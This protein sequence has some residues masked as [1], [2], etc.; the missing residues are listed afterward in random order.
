MKKLL[1]LCFL[2]L[3]GAAF[4]QSPF[5]PEYVQGEVLVKFKSNM[6]GKMTPIHSQISA[7]EVE[8]L[9]V[10]DI[11]RVRIPSNMSVTR[12]LQHY[13]SQPGVEF[14]EPNYIAHTFVVPNDPSWGSQYGPAKIQCPTGWDVN[15]GSSS[16]VIAIIDTGVLTSHPDLSGKLV[17]GYD[18]VNGDADANDDNGHGTHCAGI[19]SAATS[20]GIG[21][22]GV[23]WNCRI[24][25][26]KVLNASGSGTFANIA[27]GINF[28]TT[29]GAKVISLSL[30]GS[31]GSSTLQA[32][33]DNAVANGV[34]V[35]AAAGNSNT[36]AA[37]YPAFYTNAIAV[38]ST[39][40]ND[41]RSS[42]SNYGTWVD[43]A[44]PGSSIYSTYLNNGYA[45][46]SGTSM[47]TPHVA[48]MAG[49]LYS[50]LGSSTSAATIR[51]R[52]EN[53]CD[54]VGSFVV[55]GRVNVYRALTNGSG[56]TAPG[57]PTLAGTAGNA[58]ATLSWNAVSGA[59][60]YTLKRSNTS[61]GPYTNIASGL[62]TTNYVN[63]GLTNGTTYYYVVSAANSVGSSPNSNQVTIVPTAPPT[64]GQI[65]VNPSFENGDAPWMQTAGVIGSFTQH[66]ARTGSRN[67]WMCGYG[68]TS[69]DTLYQQVTIPANATTA[70]LNLYMK[71]TTAE[72]TTRT[73]YDRCQVQIRNSSNSVLQTLATYSNL[74]KSTGYVLRSFN[75]AA[76]R[77][78]TIRVYFNATEDSTLQTSFVVDDVTLN[79][80]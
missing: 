18:F 6:A 79:V 68:A 74:N 23:G 63:T 27:S 19:A 61:G 38:A 24:M 50:H 75:V 71:I 45:T 25:P 41:A 2:G 5:G 36:T 3:A 10:A 47:A 55:K 33:V 54:P 69:T 56:G 16:V 17:A 32:A 35:V 46:L 15:Q 9:P 62:T 44:A 51:A 78:Q 72:T 67:A 42:F 1:N 49:L 22:A 34:T 64:G 60:S 28:A 65:I 80:N 12:A 7:M 70:T 26:V 30:G 37:S 58:Q 66:P 43:V 11:R 31:S 21:I 39:D 40:Q 59:T 48:G 73:A 8:R 4:C 20:N 29:N 76:Y 57:A 14:A 77:G 52:I 13:R 53:T